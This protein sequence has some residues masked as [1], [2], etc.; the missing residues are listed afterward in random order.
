M[1]EKLQTTEA[2]E[3]RSA[4]DPVFKEEMEGAIKSGIPII[5]VETPQEAL[6]GTAMRAICSAMDLPIVE[7][8]M[9]N[10]WSQPE[11]VAKK[12]KDKDP[13]KA[14][15]LL[16][17]KQDLPFYNANGVFIFKDLEWAYVAAIGLFILVCLSLIAFVGIN[18]MQ[19]AQK[20]AEA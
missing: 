19:A 11:S 17:N 8:C 7:W 5:G 1:A 2:P 16:R 10:G 14:L 3:L 12:H 13:A 18:R 6:V 20:K 9:A 4:V 15:E